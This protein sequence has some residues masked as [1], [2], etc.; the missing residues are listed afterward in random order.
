MDRQAQF[1]V[2]LRCLF[3]TD[4]MLQPDGVCAVFRMP[5]RI[6]DKN[7]Q[8]ATITHHAI[9]TRVG[10]ALAGI[11]FAGLC[12][13]QDI[14]PRRWTPLPVGMNVLGAGIVYTE[15]DIAFDPVLELEDVTV[16][17][18]MAVVTYQH[19]F[20]LLGKS[21]RIDVRLPYKDAQWEG[22]QRGVPGT[23][24]RRGPGDPRLRL[25]VN[26]IGAPA[27]KG[28]AYQTF[29]ASHPVNTVAGAAISVTLPYGD[30]NNERL[31]NIGE[32]RL[33]FRPQL[34]VVHTRGHWSYELTGSVFLF[35][36]NDKFYFDSTRE[37]DPLYALQAHLVYT[38]PRHWWVS[39][40]AAHA[41]GGEST[42][43]GVN[44]D[45]KR[46][47]RLFGIS[48]GIPVGSSAGLKLAYV[49]SRT[50]EDVG[51]DTDNIAL[52]YSIRF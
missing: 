26:F 20:G 30:Y 32:N 8:A 51:K 12:A 34:G 23:A 9:C 13:A 18:T 45:D 1:P 46:R 43:N 29:R 7:R 33:V 19:A 25:S 40:G 10:A 50:S 11:L 14:E 36:D 48:A 42:I 41:R 15:G 47:D 16:E 27:L 4:D 5:L 31:L 22:L 39:L 35:G 52:A 17:Q 2:T 49:G 21:A 38:S 6:T 24:D 37:Q 3:I 44:K 28:K